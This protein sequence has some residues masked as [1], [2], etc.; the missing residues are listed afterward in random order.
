MIIRAAIAGF[1]LWLAG[2]LLFRLAGHTFFFPDETVILALLFGAPVVMVALAWFAMKLLGVARG[3]EAEA[4]I[5]LAL[6]GMVLDVF[7]VREFVTLFPNLDPTLDA[8]FGAL[9]LAGYGAIVF[10]GILFT[11]LAPQDERL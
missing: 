3:D 5:G 4:A 11:K 10:A 8:D 7:A 2:T 9:M 6:P 1:V